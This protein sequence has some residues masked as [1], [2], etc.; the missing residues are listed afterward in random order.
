MTTQ[1]NH[2]YIDF[3]KR[4]NISPV[5]QDISSLEKHYQRRENLY[6][7]LGLVASLVN[8]K[9]VIEFGPGSGHNAL[10]T[11]S[12]NPSRYVLVDGNPTGLNICRELMNEYYQGNQQCEFVECLIEQYSSDQL[13]DVVICEGLIPA[14][15][16][17]GQFTKMIAQ[18]AKPGGVCI[19]TCHDV[20][21]YLTDLLRCLIGSIVTEEQMPFDQKTDILVAVF[22]N[23]LAHL[24][25]MSRSCK[26]WV[27]DTIIHK[28]LWRDSKLFSVEEAI[29]ALNPAFDVYGASPYFINDWRWYKDV[30]GGQNGF[31]RVGRECYLRNIH[32]FLD[33]RYEFDPKP[34]EENQKL[35]DHCQKIWQLIT[36]FGHDRKKEYIEEMCR[37]MTALEGI[38]RA[39]SPT[40]SRAIADFV[41][42]LKKYPVINSTTDWGS[43]A[44]WW[45][46]GMQYLSFIRNT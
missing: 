1:Q 4:H 38:V 46:R 44:A 45:G 10:Y 8:G 23:H 15:K 7:R 35:L 16:D 32:N 25:G 36:R 40:T 39:F 13:F 6:R 14:Q 11:F 18:F 33:C 43:F 26:D 29:T 17:P 27:I 9:S 3:Y 28:S 34:L 37:E 2:P 31:N 5:S 19:I 20:V 22:E 24:K 41:T 42:A 21:G 12:L 30:F